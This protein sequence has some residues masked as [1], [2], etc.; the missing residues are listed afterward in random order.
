MALSPKLVREFDELVTHY[1][2]KRAG[3]IPA[4]HRCQE[5][6]GG[7]LSP[8]TIEDLSAYFGLEPVEVFG[9]A[10]F[11]PMFRLAPRGK[12]LVSVCHNISCTLRGAEELL[13]HVCKV[14]GASVGGTS[15]DGKFTVVRVECQGACANAPMFDLDGVYHEDLDDKKAEHILRSVK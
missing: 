10:S 9:V 13:A 8:E 4:L 14:T 11:Y 5:E 1:P 15:A 12:H 3:L 7:W 6:N 2:E